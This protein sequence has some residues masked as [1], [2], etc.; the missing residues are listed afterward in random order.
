LPIEIAARV[1][2]TADEVD[3]RQRQ[4][5]EAFGIEIAPQR[6]SSAGGG[7]VR[8]GK[9][10]TQHGIRAQA[11]LVRRTVQLAQQ[12]I[13]LCLLRRGETMQAW[14]EAVAHMGDGATDALAA[15]ASEIAVAQFN[16][17]VPPRAGP[18]RHNGATDRAAGAV[19]LAAVPLKNKWTDRIPVL[20]LASSVVSSVVYSYFARSR[21]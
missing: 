11:G 8:A 13:D 16:R 14:G 9:R 4:P 7:S 5:G 17:L 6:L 21:K 2:S 10:D 3:H 19:N 18:R 1:Q 20:A 15:V 12:A